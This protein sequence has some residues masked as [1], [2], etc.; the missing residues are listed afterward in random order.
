MRD[1]WI[2]EKRVDGQLDFS[3]PQP[4]QVF[5][6]GAITG[7][8]DDQIAKTVYRHCDANGRPDVI[9]D[10]RNIPHWPALVD[11]NFWARRKTW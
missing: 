10:G 1:L 8:T 3:A 2:I 7:L 4:E 9:L 6:P 11:G 5:G